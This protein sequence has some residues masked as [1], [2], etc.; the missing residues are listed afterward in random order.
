MPVPFG[1]S[2]GDF[3]AVMELTWKVTQALRE[4]AGA[5]HDVKTILETLMSFQRAISTCQTLALEW[6]QLTSGDGDG[7]TS[8]PEQSLVNGINYQLKFCRERLLKL[9]EKLEPYIRALMKQK[10]SRTARDQLYKVKWIFS[11]EEA[12]RLQK[13]LSVHVQGLERYIT[14]LGM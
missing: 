3:L 2:V 10:G 14:E 12:D 6:M 1:F 5:V 11:R 7:D 9:S 4:S 13:D 8:L